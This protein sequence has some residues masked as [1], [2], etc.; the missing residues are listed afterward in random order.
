[1]NFTPLFIGLRYIRARRRNQFISFLSGFSMLGMLL[2]VAALIIVLSVM[3]GFDRE[4]KGRLLAAIPHG[5][6]EVEAGIEDWQPLADQVTQH[7]GIVA[8]APYID[9]FAMVGFGRAL[10]AVAFTGVEPE[11][12]KAISDLASHMVM[13]DFDELQAGTYGVVIGRLLARQLAVVPGDKIQLTLP[14]LTITPAGIFPRVKR[15]TVVGVFEVGAEVDQ[16]L[17]VMHR[18]DA[19]RLLRYPAQAQ[20]LHLRTPDMFSSASVFRQ[21]Q[22]SLPEGQ[23][24]RDWTDT[25]GSLFQAIKMEKTVVTVLLLIIVMVAAFNIVTSLVLM[26]ADKRAD[27]AVL[28]TQGMSA[29]Q[30][31]WIFL[32]QGVS[33]GLVGILIGV[34][35]ACPVAFYL[36]PI[37]AWFETITGLYV[38]DPAVYF[39]SYLPSHLQWADVALVA[40]AGVVLSLLASLYPAY[41]ASRVEPAETLR[42]E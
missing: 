35:I 31:L 10:Q 5:V 28:R 39:I 9:G 37:V 6:L 40:C 42:Y 8:A 26:V 20:G 22:L 11:P 14:Q 7:P 41:R 19:R 4:L 29:G 1:M 15:F 25:Q 2:G 18:A 30:I 13:G 3:N 38:F 16:S 36:G 23:V 17:V 21:L 34:L 33:V 24:V 27:I 12:E 32:V